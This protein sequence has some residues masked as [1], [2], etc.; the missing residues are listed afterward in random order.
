MKRRVLVLFGVALFCLVMMPGCAS[1]S[2]ALVR[3]DSFGPNAIRQESDTLTIFLEEYG[4]EEKCQR[5]FDM[6]L[7]N[8]GVL[9]LLLSIQN[10][11]QESCEVRLMDIVLKNGDAPVKLLTPAEAAA[12][13]RKNAVGRAFGWSMIVPIISIPVAATA[14]VIHTN[15]VNK[16]IVQDFSAKS[17][18]EGTIMPKKDRSGFLFVQ[19]DKN[20]ADLSGLTLHVTTRPVSGGEPTTVSTPLPVLVLKEKEKKE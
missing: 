20:W 14:S 12:Q 6:N 4:T 16:Q 18:P 15:K 17:F 3:L 8:D 7:P 2:P 10:S 9:P 13:A 5:A 1:Y 19:L 11:G